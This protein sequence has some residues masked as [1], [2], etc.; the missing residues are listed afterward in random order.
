MFEVTVPCVAHPFSLSTESILMIHTRPRHLDEDGTSWRRCS[1]D[2]NATPTLSRTDDSIQLLYCMPEMTSVDHLHCLGPSAVQPQNEDRHRPLSGVGREGT[3]PHISYGDYLTETTSSDIMNN[4]K[5]SN[6]VRA[7]SR[8]LNDDDD[9]DGAGTTSDRG[10]GRSFCLTNDDD[11]AAISNDNDGGII[12]FPA[13]GGRRAPVTGG[14]FEITE[15]QLE[16]YV[17]VP[18]TAACSL[19]TAPFETPFSEMAG[20]LLVQEGNTGTVAVNFLQQAL[21]QRSTAH[22]PRDGE[23]EEDKERVT[24]SWTGEPCNEIMQ[25]RLAA[26]NHYELS[27][28]LG[29]DNRSPLF[30]PH[31]PVGTNKIPQT[32][33]CN[34]NTTKSLG[35]TIHSQWSSITSPLASKSDVWGRMQRQRS[36]GSFHSEEARDMLD[37]RREMLANWQ[38]GAHLNQ[39]ADRVRMWMDGV[40]QT[41]I[42]AAGCD[43]GVSTHSQSPS[44]SRRAATSTS[45]ANNNKA[46]DHDTC[47]GIDNDNDGSDYFWQRQG[48]GSHR[49]STSFLGAVPQ[50]YPNLVPLPPPISCVN[51]F[52]CPTPIPSI[53]TASSTVDRSVASEGGS[54]SYCI[55]LANPAAATADSNSSPHVSFEGDESRHAN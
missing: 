50:R 34:G 36:K 33:A 12:D 52:Y 31:A 5:R 42:I 27:A 16:G 14:V 48:E 23:E 26:F 9:G 1:G 21:L 10:D 51:F 32:H 22:Q 7:C 28:P 11:A 3:T 43:P 40:L 55:L 15:L 20:P 49:C 44:S 24:P 37:H 4:L 53:S 6:C 17:G 35:R 19:P 46:S 8:N 39:K 18:T 54:S 45:N 25:I 29:N 13:A 38:W 2:A 47:Q 41:E 30:Q